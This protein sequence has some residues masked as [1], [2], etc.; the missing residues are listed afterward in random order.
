VNF[1]DYLRRF[2]ADPDCN[3]REDEGISTQNEAVKEANWSIGV[4]ATIDWSADIET[5]RAQ[6]AHAVE[7]IGRSA[8]QALDAE[9]RAEIADSQPLRREAQ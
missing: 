4:R 2:K 7:V 9:L 5:V 3:A 8:D 6:T 1:R